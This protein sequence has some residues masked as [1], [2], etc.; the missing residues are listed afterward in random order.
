LEPDKAALNT[1]LYILYA[2]V[3]DV[4]EHFKSVHV[5]GFGKD[6][7]FAKESKGWWVTFEGSGEWLYF[8]ETKPDMSAGDKVKITFE[9]ATDAK[10]SATS[11]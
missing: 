6:A 7:V 1:T 9:R 3:D 4:R 8:G 2:V 10:P 11:K 5:E